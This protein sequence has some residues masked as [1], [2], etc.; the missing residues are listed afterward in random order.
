MSEGIEKFLGLDN[1]KITN[2][3]ED[4]DVYGNPLLVV[5]CNVRICHKVCPNCESHNIYR[6]GYR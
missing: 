5:D 6:D 2:V 3:T 1:L 4:E